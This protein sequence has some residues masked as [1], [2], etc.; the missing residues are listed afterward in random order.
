MEN[1]YDKWLKSWDEEEA[2]RSAAKKFLPEEEQEWVR[3]K[4]D[5]K[6][7][8][9]CGRENGFMTAGA[10][11]LAIIP[12][13]WNTGKHAHGEEAIFIVQ[14][15]GFTVLDGQRY[16][17]DAGSCLFMP[18]GSVHQHFNSGEEEVRYL[19]MTAIALERFAGVAKLDQCEAA[20]E[21]YIDKT[22]GVPT[23]G[24]DIHPEH[25]R[26]VLRLKDAPV[27]PGEEMAAVH[28]S[29]KDEFHQTLAKEMKTPGMTGHRSRVIELMAA[30]ENQF[31]AREVQMTNVLC[32]EPGGHSGKHSHM[33][34]ILYVLQGEGYSIIDG[35]KIPWK[36]GTLLHVQGPQT[37]HQHFNTSKIESQQ[38]RMHYG[39]RSHFYQPI[40]RS[41][42]PY[43][44]YEFSSYG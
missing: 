21:T 1:F 39:L 36:R 41:V 24:S 20:G 32:D 18:Y 16:D 10:V 38:L 11:V 12:R 34:A 35:E 43:R 30:P 3:T 4:Q 19:S 15:K 13:G 29:R 27:T 6:A 7:A 17:W 14:G 25:G 44:Y 8:L 23:A 5:Y 22:T 42:F 9:L 26:I 37:V 33:E 40:A 2:E 31:K 28:A